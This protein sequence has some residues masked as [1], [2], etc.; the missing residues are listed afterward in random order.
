M[1]KVSETKTFAQIKNGKL[2]YREGVII[3]KTIEQHPKYDF[4]V[5]REIVHAIEEGNI[6]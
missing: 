6:Q 3:G 4:L 5:G 1:F 2:I